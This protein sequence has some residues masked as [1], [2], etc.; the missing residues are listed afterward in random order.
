MKNP[1][2]GEY[3]LVEYYAG[4]TAIYLFKDGECLLFEKASGKFKKSRYHFTYK[5]WGKTNLEFMESFIPFKEKMRK[6]N[7]EEI[8]LLI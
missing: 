5:A 1:E 4:E 8:A 6:I 7:K 2:D 3:Y